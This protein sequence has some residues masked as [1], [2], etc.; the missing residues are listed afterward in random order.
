MT[1]S[2]D[3]TDDQDDDPNADNLTTPLLFANDGTND[4]SGS[5]NAHRATYDI[6]VPSDGT[7]YLWGR[8]Y[9]PGAPG[10][11][12]ANSFF[13]S[14]GSG[15]VQRFGNNKDQFETWHWDGDGAVETGALVG[16]SLGNLTAGTKTLAIKKREVVPTPPRLDVICIT[17]D[18]NLP[19]D[20]AEVCALLGCS[21]GSTTTVPTS[22][23][24]S[25]SSTIIVSPVSTSTTSST[26]SSTLPPTV[27]VA[28]G[29]PDTL[30]GTM[31]TGTGFTNGQDNDPNANN[32]TSPLLFPNS[33]SSDFEGTNGDQ[34]TYNV[35]LP[36]S[37][38]WYLWGRFY[39]PGAVG[40]NDPNSFFAR[41]DNGT[42]FRFG[43]NKDQ[44]QLWHWDGDGAIETGAL[45]GLPL[46][47]LTAGSRTL[48]IRRREA[49]SNIQP[50]LDVVCFTQD[51]STE[52][53]ESVVCT[54][55]GTCIP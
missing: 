4:F 5:S 51:P 9:Y 44:F 14:V 23:T 42:L 25:T 40:S 49:A 11:N 7:W 27:C 32:L 1:T 50:R 46:G 54:Q 31:T 12:D 35:N 39:Y 36:Q 37:G 24:S 55:L 30:A 43:N 53:D 20:E 17:K 29:S 48:T 8:F 18:A 10:S 52:P 33:S 38:P 45:S 34:A 28:A 6:D 22:S 19:P 2:T 21:I 13:A 15:G 3:F 47:N 16:L 26:T 41:V